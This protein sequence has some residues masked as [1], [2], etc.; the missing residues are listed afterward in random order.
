MTKTERDTMD[1]DKRDLLA[2]AKFYQDYSRWSEKEERHETWNEAVSRVM[3]MHRQFY[4]KKMTPELEQLISEA[5]AL[6]KLKYALGAQ[7]ALQFGGDQILQHHARNFNCCASSVH[8]DAF[9]GLMYVLLAGC[10]AGM[11][12]QKHHVERLPEVAV[13]NKQAKA[14][15]VEDSIEGWATSL[16]VMMS[17]FFVDGGKYPE[18]QGRKVFFDL[19]NIRERG[20]PISGGFKAPGP[21]PLGLAL[22]RIEALLHKFVTDGGKKLRPIHV[23]DIML[24]AA[25]AVIAGGVRRSATIFLFSPD[26]EEMATAKTGDWFSK[27]PQRAR[28]NNSAV[29]VRDEIERP[30]FARLMASVK[31]YGEPGFVF[32]ADR[33]HLTNPCAE[34]QLLPW[35][36]TGKGKK[37]KVGWEFCNLTEISGAKCTSEEEF[38]KACRAA[39]IMGTLQAGYTDFKFLG[40]VTKK[41]VEREALLGVSITGWMNSPG[42]LFNPETLRKGA[43]IVKEVNAQVA[44]MIGINP[45]ARCTTVKPSGNASTILET[46]SGIHPEHS[47]RYLRQMEM[48]KDSDI[49]ELMQ[50]TNPYMCEDSVWSDKAIKVS[51][52]VIPPE[53]SVFKK[54]MTAIEFLEKVKLVQET[55]IEEGSRDEVSVDPRARHNVSNTVSVQDHEWE[56]VEEFLFENRHTFAG[57]SLLPASGDR[58]YAQ[59]PFTSVPTAAEI[60]EKYGDASMF[61]S[62]LIV[63][64][65]NGFRDLWEACDCVL[66]PGDS[67]AKGEQHDIQAGWIRRFEKFA[68]NF[69]G[70]DLKKASYCLKDVHLLHKWNKIQQNMKPVDFVNGLKSRKMVDIDTMAASACQGGGCEI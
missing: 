7:R 15:I 32:V 30:D 62:G 43:R 41:I 50:E 38:F 5:E 42:I 56:E 52:P 60:V 65:N 45:A 70:G 36:E 16:D 6:Y 26:D 68:G 23:Y 8:V 39:S 66:H 69:F 57:V 49:A 28:S 31:D 18:Y 58:D 19:S 37:R 25:D 20:A 44:E 3:S 64:A 22:S 55:W 59:A 40:G 54:D 47:P 53:C 21:E 48:I 63:G 14:H 29:I 1:I 12:V 51:V 9:G 24:H 13:R 35:L 2:E 33:E 67:Q 17:S 46:A 11:S 34:I 10:G 27:N 61:A 4:A